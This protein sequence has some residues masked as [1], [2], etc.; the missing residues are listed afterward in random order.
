[1][2]SAAPYL[3]RLQ[4]KEEAASGHDYPFH[5]PQIR[6]LDIEVTSPV[7]FFVGENGTGKSTV[8]EAVAE[9]CR[10]PVSGGGRHDLAD[11]HGPERSS[12]LAGALRPS[13]RRRPRDAYF[14][15]SEFQAHFATLLEQR[16]Q[17]PAQSRQLLEA[18]QRTQLKRNIGRRSR[19]PRDGW[20]SR[21]KPVMWSRT[22]YGWRGSRTGLALL[23]RKS[24]TICA[25]ARMPTGN[26]PSSARNVGAWLLP[27]CFGSDSRRGLRESLS[28]VDPYGDDLAEPSRICS[29]YLKVPPS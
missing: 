23:V 18:P 21:S 9:L 5:L 29:D 2:T 17:D 4:L 16:R 19:V 1:M 11:H 7:T 8:I 12:A 27:D 24:E 10:L 3:I 15:R 22:S 25:T 13:F 6:N 14:L 28:A 20:A 26:A